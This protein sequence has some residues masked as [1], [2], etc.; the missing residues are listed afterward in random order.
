[1]PSRTAMIV[2]RNLIHILGIFAIFT[3]IYISKMFTIA[4]ISWLVLVYVMHLLFKHHPKLTTL[5]IS[6]FIDKFSHERF[7]R[8]LDFGPI[9]FGVGLILP[10]LF[11]PENIAYASIMILVLGDG[12]CAMT[13]LLERWYKRLKLYREA[14]IEGTIIGG[15]AGFVGAVFFVSPIIA[16]LGAIVGIVIE[17]FS[18]TID[19]NLLIPVFTGF[20]MSI[21]KS[22]LP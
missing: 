4:M 15:L 9:F 5:S 19:D 20:F 6:K 3:S 18:Q 22:V 10:L 14:T 17:V 11:F 8:R 1:V 7:T 12:F 2:R 16:L 21:M 13:V